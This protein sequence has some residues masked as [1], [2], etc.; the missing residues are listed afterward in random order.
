MTAHL[1]VVPPSHRTPEAEFLRIGSDPVG[2]P[3]EDCS[4]ICGRH[5]GDPAD[6][7]NLTNVKT[8]ASFPGPENDKSSYAPDSQAAS[9]SGKGLLSGPLVGVR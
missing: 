3:E 4:P 9:F 7:Y 6:L 1:S 2:S 8:T 5:R